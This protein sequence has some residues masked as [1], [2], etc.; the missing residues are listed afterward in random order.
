[1]KKTAN[2][3]S[4]YSYILLSFV[5]HL[6]PRGLF[7]RR[8][9]MHASRTELAQA[10]L[11]SVDKI[12]CFF[13]AFEFLCREFQE[14]GRAA[15]CINIFARLNARATLIAAVD[16]CHPTD[17]PRR[18]PFSR[19][20]AAT[21]AWP[22]NSTGGLPPLTYLNRYQSSA[23]VDVQASRRAAVHAV[24]SSVYVGSWERI[25]HDN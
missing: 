1:M 8:C 2:N 16:G 3:S 4:S 10:M 20:W 25:C 5:C 18:E 19:I 14:N 6:Y 15:V 23:L 13:S 7:N 11:V 22:L 24:L 12:N 17:T 9:I 21:N